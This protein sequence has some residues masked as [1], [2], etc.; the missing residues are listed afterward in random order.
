MPRSV[1]RACVCVRAQLRFLLTLTS[2]KGQAHVLSLVARMASL[3]FLTVEGIN[4][5]GRLTC[6]TRLVTTY[7]ARG[8]APAPYVHRMLR[9]T[10]SVTYVVDLYET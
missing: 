8:C 3:K 2:W 1:L 4:S 6:R 10:L 5:R 7:R 9:A